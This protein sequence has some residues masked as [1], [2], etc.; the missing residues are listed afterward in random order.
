[1]K[2]K[3]F[4][5]GFTLIELMVVVAIVGILAAIAY[6]SYTR[7]VADARRADAQT[8]MFE[9]AQFMERY[10]VSNGRY[11][12]QTGAAPDLPFTKTPRDGADEFYTL[13]LNNVSNSTYTL[14]ATIK[15]TTG[16]SCGNLTL[17]HN[18]VKGASKGSI[19]DCW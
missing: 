4:N 18:G 8:N 12:T 17:T 2:T 3:V 13:A 7:Y 15:V 16:D 9:L 1:M 14:T 11:T 10:Y 5:K 6:P 19:D